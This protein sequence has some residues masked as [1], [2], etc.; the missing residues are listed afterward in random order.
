M[1][2]S[3]RSSCRCSNQIE[4][5]RGGSIQIWP[6]LI[7]VD[8]ARTNRCWFLTLIFCANGRSEKY[9]M[10]WPLWIHRYSQLAMGASSWH[11]STERQPN[12][13][14][15]LSL[16]FQLLHYVGTKMFSG[17]WL[18]TYFTVVESGSMASL[19]PIPLPLLGFSLN[20]NTMLDYELQHKELY[21][22]I[23]NNP[24]NI[25]FRNTELKICWVIFNLWI[26]K[27]DVNI[28]CNH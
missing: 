16:I 4:I 6:S 25:N 24:M 3:S 23:Q 1:V 15:K 27:S 2:L 21:K 12:G 8:F 17:N 20:L 11:S 28:F 5:L 13:C 26:P 18:A 10:C 22:V 19:V 7:C 9:Q 14:N